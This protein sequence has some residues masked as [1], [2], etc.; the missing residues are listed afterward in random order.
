M[1][2]GWGSD[3]LIL[4]QSSMYSTCSVS[5]RHM[6]ERALFVGVSEDEDVIA[7]LSDIVAQIL[8]QWMTHAPACCMVTS[9]PNSQHKTSSQQSC[10]QNLFPTTTGLQTILFHYFSV[11]QCGQSWPK[12]GTK[13]IT[14]TKWGWRSKHSTPW[15]ASSSPLRTLYLPPLPCHF[16]E[17]NGIHSSFQKSQG[18]NCKHFFRFRHGLCLLLVTHGMLLHTAQ[19]AATSTK[20]GPASSQTGGWEQEPLPAN[21]PCIARKA[22]QETPC[23]DTIDSRY[24]Y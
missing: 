5:R 20:W 21:F 15:L 4:V 11:V 1:A 16:C 19:R 18:N 12:T 13:Q 17:W 3:R 10:I 9:H 8:N 2:F 22:G 14:C 23:L 7:S 6:N 24:T